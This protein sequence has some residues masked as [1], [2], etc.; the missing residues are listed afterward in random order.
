MYV[1]PGFTERQSENP[2]NLDKMAVLSYLV[3]YTDFMEEEIRG[4]REKMN[5]KY[6]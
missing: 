2:P 6:S 1:L 3:K 4:I 5:K